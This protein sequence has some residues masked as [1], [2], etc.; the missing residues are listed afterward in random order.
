MEW[1]WKATGAEVDEELGWGAPRLMVAVSPAMRACD[2]VPSPHLIWI[3]QWRCFMTTREI[4][5]A[6][7]ITQL[8]QEVD[9]L[10]RLVAALNVKRPQ[11][12]ITLRKVA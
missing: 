4:A 6:V 10:S 9:T 12:K 8:E 3:S 5:T 7:A 1:G 11:H 2:F